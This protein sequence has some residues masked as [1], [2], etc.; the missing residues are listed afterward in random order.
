MKSKNIYLHHMSKQLREE[1]HKG[2]ESAFERMEEISLMFAEDEVE[3]TN[4]QRDL[5]EEA[6]EERLQSIRWFYQRLNGERLECICDDYYYPWDESCEVC[7]K[8]PNDSTT[9]RG[10]GKGG[11]GDISCRCD[12]IQSYDDDYSYP[13][14]RGLHS[15]ASY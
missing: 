9:C 12:N 10:C 1:E 6:E 2:D 14:W 15:D 13:H 7:G 11:Y 3:R 5:A 8:E 4:E